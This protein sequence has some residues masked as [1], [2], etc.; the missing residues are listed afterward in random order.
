MYVD[1]ECFLPGKR[2]CYPSVFVT[3][4]YIGHRD[5]SQLCP[6][7]TK[8]IVHFMCSIITHPVLFSVQVVLLY[9]SLVRMDNVCLSIS[10]VMVMMTVEIT[11]MKR[12]VVRI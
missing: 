12:T 8:A 11:V 6:G 2:Y 4:T 1:L 9:S 10:S 7:H 3:L 5:T